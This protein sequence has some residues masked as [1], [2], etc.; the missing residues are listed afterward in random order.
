LLLPPPPGGE[1]RDVVARKHADEFDAENERLNL[2]PSALE[3]ELA[4]EADEMDLANLD[5]KADVANLVTKADLDKLATKEDFDK[6]LVELKEASRAE[7][8]KGAVLSAT[9]L[10]VAYH[11][12][13]DR[14]PKP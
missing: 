13:A 14:L 2:V 10:F 4:K 7:I 5:D 1:G 3:G 9:T 11:A 8:L 12:I 6:F